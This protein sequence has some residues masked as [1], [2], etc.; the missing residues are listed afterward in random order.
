MKY[1]VFISFLLLV[2]CKKD[3]TC[4]CR[5]GDGTQ[6]GSTVYKGNKKDKAEAEKVCEDR[7]AAEKIA[8]NDP[9]FH[10][11]LH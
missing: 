4:E 6:Q 11:E 3:Y 5:R 1:Y 8:Y 9:L 10:C 2:S 7:E